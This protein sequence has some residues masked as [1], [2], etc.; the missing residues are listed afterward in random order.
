MTTAILPLKNGASGAFSFTHDDGGP[1]NWH[2]AAQILHNHG[3]AGTFYLIGASVNSWYSDSGKPLPDWKFHVPQVLAARAMGH[4]VACHTYNHKRLTSLTHQEVEQQYALNR[5]YFLKWGIR[6]TGHAYP[7][8]AT[9]AEIQE[10]ASRY[11]HFARG[12]APLAQ[13]PLEWSEI[14]PLD[15]RLSA[16]ADSM[17]SAIDAAVAGNTWGVGVFHIDGD[18][19]YPAS[20]YEQIIAHAVQKVESGDLWVATFSD[21]AQYLRQRSSA[22]VAE[23]VVLGGL[24]ISLKTTGALDFLVP[25][26]LTTDVALPVSGV[27]Q[28]GMSIPWEIVGQAVRYDAIPNAG[29]VIIAYSQQTTGL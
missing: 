8:G 5:D 1:G 24:S 20:Q 17:I 9:N 14:N 26:T 18:L 28:S 22:T 29:D 21:V 10:I 7:N 19:G 23:K 2:H 12:V 13:N 4:E 3:L 11:V 16:S 6:L 15:I 27:S 25:M